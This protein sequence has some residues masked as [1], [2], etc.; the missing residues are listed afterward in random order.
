MKKHMG[1]VVLAALLVLALL[2]YMATYTVAY[3]EI[4][5]LKT[6]GDIVHVHDGGRDAGLH[7]KWPLVQTIQ[8]YDRRIF[9]IEDPLSELQTSDQLN[10]VCSFSC[11]WRIDDPE[12]F[13]RAVTDMADAEKKIL[14]LLRNSK[15][16]VINNHAMAHFVNVAKGEM[17]QARIEQEVLAPLREKCRQ[18]YGIDVVAVGFKQLGV[19][20]SVSESIIETIKKERQTAID[21]YKSEGR[22]LATAIKEW[23]KTAK[24]EIVSFAEKKAADIRA[25]G[26]RIA[27]Q[28]YDVYRDAPEFAMFLRSLESL[29]KELRTRTVI[30]LDSGLLPA[31][32]FFLTG[33]TT[34]VFPTSSPLSEAAEVSPEAAEA[35][36]EVS[37]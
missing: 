36:R 30:V 35:R 34:E 25:S 8:R 3:N 11:S 24:Q 20:K 18:E 4:V 26:I 22:A 31:V 14:T 33:P 28:Y 6:F 29:E 19:N 16:D 9:T 13:N 37:P 7:F 32:Q 5:L 15:G 10:I 21:S 23:A 17:R 27:Q 1:L 2:A 12:R